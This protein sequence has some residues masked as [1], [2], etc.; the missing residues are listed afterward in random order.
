MAR[1]TWAMCSVVVLNGVRA[2]YP[3][4]LATNRDEFYARAS[5]G[6]QRLLDAPRSVG[7]RDLVAHGTWA[8]V[9]EHGLFVGVTNQRTL[10]PPDRSKRSRGGWGW[11]WRS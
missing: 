6:P 2:D 5:S 9:T 10:A 8:A 11:H 3:V 1:Y 7:G 4:V